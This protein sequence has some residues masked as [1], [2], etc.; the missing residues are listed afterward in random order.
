MG[1]SLSE[2]EYKVLKALRA[3]EKLGLEELEK[4]TGLD[5]Q[6]LMAIAELLRDKGIVRVERRVLYRCRLTEEGRRAL[7][8]GLPEEKLFR[9]LDKLGGAAEI[10]RLVEELGRDTFSIG[11]G[12]LKKLG[13]AKVEGGRVALT[14]EEW[15]PP[16]RSLVEECARGVSVE[17]GSP[18]EK[19]LRELA[20]RNLAELVEEKEFLIR[21][22]ADP[23]EVLARA[24]VEVSRLTPEMLADG[25]WRS[26]V[27]KRYNVTAEPPRVYPGKKHF[28]VEFINM[29]RRVLYEMGFAEAE[30]PYVE[31]EFWNFDVLF[32]AQDHP[33]REIH[34]TFWLRRPRWGRLD[35]R[36]EIVERVKRIHE[37][38]GGTGSR[39]WGYRWNPDTARR[40]ILRTQTT[41]VSARVL[42]GSR[43]VPLRVF[44]I[45]KVFRPDVI[46][47]KHLPEFYQFDGIV[48]EEDMSFARLLGIIKEFFERLGIPEVR[49]KP[50][51][52]P[53]TEPSVEG[54]IYIEGRGWVEVFGAGMFRPEVLASLGVEHPVGAWGMGLDRIAMDIM[55][56]DDIRKLYTRRVDYLR[57]A[58]V[59]W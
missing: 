59:R 11:V 5:R 23:G 35:E 7:E 36:S 13:A 31:M 45:G 42:A 10:R 56:L 54:Y 30:G 55:G 9:L 26:Y 49:F 38:G 57:E 28:Y 29:V 17:A 44:T 20:S 22:V 16:H 46:D 14:V 43:K 25:A 40:L 50:G 2:N 47:A 6:T 58:P 12:W 32:Q 37:T 24:R 27:F 41:A 34:D 3:G 39:G 33:A 18:G 52:F 48:M 1:L 8:E 21:V 51:Y 15:R 53:F 19:A 4:R